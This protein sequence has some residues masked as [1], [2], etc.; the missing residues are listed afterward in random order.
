[1]V[2]CLVLELEK[3]LLCSHVSLI[4]NNVHIHIYAA[5][6]VLL[7]HLHIVKKALRLEITCADSSH[8]H[9]VQALMFTSEFLADL[10]I[11]VKGSVDLTLDERIFDIDFLK[12]RGEGGMTAMVAPVCVEDTEF[13]LGRV[14]AFSLEIIDN[15]AKVISVHR[16]THLLA[17]WG[18]FVLGKCCKAF[19]DRNRSHLR[20][21]H[22]REFSK[23]LLTRLHRI[24]VIF[25]DLGKSLIRC[26]CRKNYEFR[27]LDAHL[28][29]RV[30]QTHTVHC[31]SGTLVKLARK[32]FHC[33][34]SCT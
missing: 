34:I 8:I 9:E 14:A 22:C 1:M 25:L 7:A 4:V 5:C 11:E 10:H 17:V 13:G 32:A 26:L 2:M 21:L 19:K 33:D 23:I 29:R 3:P 28:C 18:K 30:D 15:L 24:Y 6:I 16:K 27:T 12:F 31:R 20:L